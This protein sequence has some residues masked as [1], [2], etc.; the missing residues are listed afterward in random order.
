MVVSS[1]GF[2]SRRVPNRQG[3]ILQMS[4]LFGEQTN[5]DRRSVPSVVSC[6]VLRIACEECITGIKMFLIYEFCL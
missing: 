3:A 1:L 6:N 5:Q 4:G 2:V